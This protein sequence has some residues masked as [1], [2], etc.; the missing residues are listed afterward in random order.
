M[1]EHP[2]VV[3]E[4]D[5]IYYSMRVKDSSR[6]NSMFSTPH[7]N[8]FILQN[9]RGRAE[10]GQLLAIMGPT[11]KTYATTSGILSYSSEFSPEWIYLHIF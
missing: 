11:G 1:T 10:S 5:H 2:K 6:A 9:L 8:N 7:K 3:L 4:W